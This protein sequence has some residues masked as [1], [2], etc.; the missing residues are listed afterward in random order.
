MNRYLDLARHPWTGA[1]VHGEAA[2]EAG[3]TGPMISLENW[4]KGVFKSKA[5]MVMACIYILFILIAG[6]EVYGSKPE[7]MDGFGLLILTAPWSFLLGIFLSSVGIITLENGDS[8]LIV[9]IIFGGAIN[10][11]ILLVVGHFLTKLFE[12]LTTQK[13][14]LS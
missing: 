13:K 8:Y 6:L 11:A 4:M 3:E 9:L 14:K 10:I 2:A 1:N 7:P 12:Y 5:G